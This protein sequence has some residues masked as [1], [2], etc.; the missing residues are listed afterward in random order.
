MTVSL[1]TLGVVGTTRGLAPRAGTDWSAEFAVALTGVAG[2]ADF[3]E[4]AGPA[5]TRA[6]LACAVLV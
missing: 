5:A 2:A 6:D 4:P 3:A 1:G